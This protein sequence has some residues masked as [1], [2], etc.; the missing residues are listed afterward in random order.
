MV[1]RL[2]NPLQSRPTPLGTLLN[3]AG[4]RLGAQLDASLRASGFGDLRAAHAPL[5][6]AIEPNGSTVTYLA[7]RTS[8][9]KQAMGELVGYLAGCGYLEVT[10]D[11]ND[12]RARRI[13]LT[14]RGW[15]AI[16]AATEVIDEFD[17]WLE[18]CVGSNGVRQLRETLARILES[19]PAE[20]D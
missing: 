9:T 18:G 16:D 12:R 2:I 1:K 4:R 10:I 20:S 5:F 14:D 11:P 13:R 3:A 19:Q 8:M 15:H 7:E 17:S 6:M